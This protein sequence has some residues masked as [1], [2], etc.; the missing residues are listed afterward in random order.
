MKKRKRIL[1]I[2]LAS[3]LA[4]G[5]MSAPAYGK[6]YDVSA[7][8]KKTS[9]SV[10]GVG[11]GSFPQLEEGQAMTVDA[12]TERAIMRSTT[13]NNYRDS[14]KVAEDQLDDVV[15][16]RRVSED[17]NTTNN[18]AI[19]Y[20]TLI[21]QVDTLN[22]RIEAE[23]ESL[24]FRIETCFTNI[25]E[26][27]NRLAIYDENIDLASRSLDISK[28][29]YELGSLSKSQYDT[30]VQNYN[31]IVSGKTALEN[32]IESNYTELNTIL[33]YNVGA[34]YPVEIGEIEYTLVDPGTF[35][36]RVAAATSNANVNIA[37]LD[38]NAKVAEF[39]LDRHSDFRSTTSRVQREADVYSATSALSDAKLRYEGAVKT[40]YDNIK[41]I[42]ENYKTLN[43]QLTNLNNNISIYEKQYE[44]GQITKLQLDNYYYSQKDLAN[45]IQEALYSHYLLVKQY[46]NPNLLS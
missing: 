9:A 1:P 4:I 17:W 27:K 44:L 25:I 31:S 26:A 15:V 39:A 43:D 30:A 38:R 40:L 8:N 13:I 20:Q 28:K 11:N 3:A 32:Q 41:L 16:F 7:N 42:E 2:L 37:A 10:H 45:S 46:E 34:E 18:Y 36:A 21:S 14:I 29:Q 23:K 6:G 12:A 19:S 22:E 33:D 5:T 24:R 35:N